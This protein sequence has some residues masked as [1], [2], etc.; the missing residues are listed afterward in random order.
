MYAPHWNMVSKPTV[1]TAQ[2]M[3]PESS[4]QVTALSPFA[5]AWGFVSTYK[6]PTREDAECTNSF[7]LASLAREG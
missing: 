6:T 1:G 7:V 4:V 5:T 3:R 2:E